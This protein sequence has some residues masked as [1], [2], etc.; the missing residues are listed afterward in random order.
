LNNEALV[1][2]RQVFL[3]DSVEASGPSLRYIAS[4]QARHQIG[5]LISGEAA[6]GPP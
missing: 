3:E 2:G 6:K 1:Y 4:A 5:R